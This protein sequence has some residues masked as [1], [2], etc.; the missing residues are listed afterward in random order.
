MEAVTE[1]TT[2]YTLLTAE[3]KGADCACRRGSV[4]SALPFEAT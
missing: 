1:G 4:R 2:S 3:R